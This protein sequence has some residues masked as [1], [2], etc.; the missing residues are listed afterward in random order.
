MRGLI[1]RKWIQCCQISCQQTFRWTET[2]TS[3]TV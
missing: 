1:I 2:S 3:S